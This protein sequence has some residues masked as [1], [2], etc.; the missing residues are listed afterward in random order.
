[1]NQLKPGQ[2]RLLAVGLLVIVLLLLIRILL[3]PLWAAWSDYGSQI[4]ALENRLAVYERTVTGMD[5]N[6]KR[7]AEL[8]ARQPATDWYLS[9]TTPALSAAAL[10]QM[11]HRQVTTNGAQVISSQIIERDEDAP[12]QSVAIQAHLRGE[13]SELVGLLYTLEDGRPVLFIDNV[14][15]LA[16]PRRQVSR[17]RTN[18][19]AQLPALDVRFDL[20]GYTGWE[21][22]P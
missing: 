4:D 2:S 22:S 11:L 5:E 6:Q 7:L 13:L 1:M 15:I 21:R 17:Q 19:R 9:E 18:A 12:L 8:K 16:N 20:I 10:Q 14:R 3:V